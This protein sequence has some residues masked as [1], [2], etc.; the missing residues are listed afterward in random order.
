MS[1]E[2]ED[3]NDLINRFDWHLLP[4]EIQRL[5][6]IIMANAQQPVGFQCFGSFIC[7]RDTFKTVCVH[8]HLDKI[9]TIFQAND[10]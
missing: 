6:P 8:F 4:L 2:F 5:L 3:I 9:E 10:D 7:N 1:S